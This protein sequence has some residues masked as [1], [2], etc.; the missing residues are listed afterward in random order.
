MIC[1]E[2]LFLGVVERCLS[3]CPF[4]LSESSSFILENSKSSLLS[5]ETSYSSLFVPPLKTGLL[6]KCILDLTEPFSAT[7]SVSKIMWLPTSSTRWRPLSF[8]IVSSL[9]LWIVFPRNMSFFSSNLFA[10]TLSSIYGLGLSSSTQFTSISG[11]L[12]TTL[13]SGILSTMLSLLRFLFLAYFNSFFSLSFVSCFSFS[14][15]C[16]ISFSWVVRV[17]TSYYSFV[18]SF[19]LSSMVFSFCLIWYLSSSRSSFLSQRCWIVLLSWSKNLA[20]TIESLAY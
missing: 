14:I 8:I 11:I 7:E 4:W 6:R 19:F 5:S 2:A 10:E 17:L 1:G 16:C 13:I 20:P 15:F 9:L 18:N 12:L 3:L